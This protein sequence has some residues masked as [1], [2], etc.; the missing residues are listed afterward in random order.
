MWRVLTMPRFKLTTLPTPIEKASNLSRDLGVNLLIKRD[1]VMELALGGN[2][3][4]KLEFILADALSKGADVLITRGAIHSNHA[5]LTAAAAR[6]AGLEAHLVLTPPGSKEVI[7]GNLLLDSL[8]G[9]KITYVENGEDADAVMERIAEE[10]KSSG[11]RPYII[12]AGGAS[13]YG[14]LGYALAALEIIQQTLALNVRPKYIIHTTGT[15]AT[16]AGLIL[17]LKAL[18]VDDVKVIG[19]SNGRK[20]S[21]EQARVLKLVNQ[22]SKAFNIEVKVTSDDVIVYD[23][24]V[25][26]G[27]GVITKEVVDTMKYVARTEGLILD[28]VYTAKGMYG[29]IDLIHKGEIRRNENV[30]FI[31]TGGSPITFQYVDNVLKWL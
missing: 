30:V 27:Y 11:R 26:G 6:K 7:Q 8:L 25:F 15:G 19:I 14:V 13:E 17:G 31:H 16:Q 23:D 3:V 22:A 18:G 29:L 2:K 28:P 9:A 5:R 20:A 21:E 4:R 10:L 1:D 12:P 24:Y